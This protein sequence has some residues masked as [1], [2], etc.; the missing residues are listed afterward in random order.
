MIK[1]ILWDVDGALFDTYPAITYAVS[2]SLNEMGCSLALNV[3]DGLARQSLSHCVETL[4]QRF[5][6]DPD[7]LRHRFSETYRT[8][9]P[10]NQP[11]FPGVREVC[12]LIH[13]SGGLNI[14]VT[15]RGVQS[16]RTLLEAHALTPFF[17]DIFSVEQGYA[18][19]PDP[20]MLLAALEKYTL[21]PAESL[22][23]GDRE[24]DIQ[25]GRAA[26]VHTCLFGGTELATPADFQI[27]RYAQLLSRL[28][29]KDS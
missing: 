21:N 22:L 24:L 8:I 4:S 13:Q 5:K 28:Q 29:G 6:L 15:H 2:R 17:D 3:I 9:D 7:L 14:A 18:R 20:A 27:E 16:T 25:A 10:A 12:K 11:P 19:K 23:V 1:N 26:G